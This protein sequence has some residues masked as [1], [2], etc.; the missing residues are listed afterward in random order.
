[1]NT[2]RLFRVYSPDAPQ[3]VVKTWACDAL[4]AVLEVRQANPRFARMSNVR[5]FPA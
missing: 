4:Q 3:V 5:A 1:M 2:L